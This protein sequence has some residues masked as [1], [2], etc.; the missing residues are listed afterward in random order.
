LD[1]ATSTC[2][3]EPMPRHESLRHATIRAWLLLTEA[4]ALAALAVM[5]YLFALQG[6]KLAER[7]TART[8]AG[9]KALTPLQIAAL[10]YLQSHV[11]FG[12]ASAA[13]LYSA[14]TM[15]LP[16]TFV[17]AWVQG[18]PRPLSTSALALS[19]ACGVGA[20]LTAGALDYT[21]FNALRQRLRATVRT[22]APWRGLLACCYGG[23]AEE[24]LMRLGAQTILAAGVRHLAH[25]LTAPPSPNTMWAAIAVSNLLFGVGHLPTARGV[26]PLS[27]R[28]VARTLVLNGVAGTVFG[29][30]Y[31]KRGLEA[32]MIAHGAADLTL[33]VAGAAVTR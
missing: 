17:E 9:T 20:A 22:P 27:P 30:L 23:S 6:A 29:Y 15:G 25:G 31:W 11:T 16:P 10:S 12:V 18:E 7:N 3:A 21:V 24:V 2:E 5:P 33:H 1:Q 4:S 32:A 19:A 13:G 14:K 8:V 26:M 28:F